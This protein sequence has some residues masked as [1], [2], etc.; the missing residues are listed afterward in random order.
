MVPPKQERVS[1]Q[2]PYSAKKTKVE[3][4]F[5]QSTTVIRTKVNTERKDRKKEVF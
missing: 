3:Q 1:D 2:G 4:T 5:I